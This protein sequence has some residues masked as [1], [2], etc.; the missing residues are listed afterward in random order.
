M[1][2]IVGIVVAIVLLASNLIAQKQA[3]S[4][5]ELAK[6]KQDK[7]AIKQMEGCYKVSFNF[8]ETFAPDTNYHFHDRYHSEATEYAI[9]IEETDTKISIQHL[10]VVGPGIVV[11]HWRQDWLYENTKL[12]NFVDKGMWKKTSISPKQAD[13]TWTQKVY[14]VDDSPRYQG[15]GTWI[16]VDGRHFWESSAF[17]PLPRRERTHRSDYNVLERHYHIEMFE[18]S[19]LLE[20]DNKKIIRKN[21]EDKVLVAEKGIERFTKG[22]FNC[23][24]AV[25]WWK[26]NKVFWADVRK[27][28]TNLIAHSAEVIQFKLKVDGERMYEKM[29]EAGNEF[30]IAGNYQSEAG[31]KKIKEIIDLYRIK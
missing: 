10:L 14:L 28:W 15:Y 21:G 23:K 30:R 2:K 1:K 6:I 3:F 22:N 5:Q 13:G 7:E 16:H 25:D 19:W 24:P 27:V 17:A 31:L 11:K 26:E 9:I 20:Q 29:F 8:A 4:K 18:D 12:L